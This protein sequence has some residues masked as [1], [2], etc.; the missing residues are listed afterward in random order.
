MVDVYL[1]FDYNALTRSC[2]S[3]FA[4]TKYVINPIQFIDAGSLPRLEQS[5]FCWGSIDVGISG[6]GIELP[7]SSSSGFPR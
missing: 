1:T 3:V 2:N 7:S 4:L 6:N 5:G